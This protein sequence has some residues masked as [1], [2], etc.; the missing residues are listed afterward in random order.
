[1]YGGGGSLGPQATSRLL[2]TP[3]TLKILKFFM[4]TPM[5]AYNITPIYQ[6]KI[7]F[8][9]KN[10]DVCKKVELNI[11]KIGQVMAILSL[12]KGFKKFC[13]L[14]RNFYQLLVT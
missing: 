13:E 12:K 8:Y 5:T 4:L 6:S 11:L 2:Q 7:L 14:L 10:G 1:M 9:N 3:E